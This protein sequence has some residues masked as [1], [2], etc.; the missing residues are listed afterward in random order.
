MKWYSEKGANSSQKMGS[1]EGYTYFYTMGLICPWNY[2]HLQ[3][4]PSAES[5]TARSRFASRCFAVDKSLLLWS[6]VGR[7]QSLLSV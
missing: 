4:F 6:S 3:P 5:A 1:G 2:S 7:S